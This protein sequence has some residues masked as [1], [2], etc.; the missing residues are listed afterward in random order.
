MRFPIVAV[1]ELILVQRSNYRLH[2][3]LKEKLP[4]YADGMYIPIHIELL[5]TML[6]EQMQ[7][8]YDHPEDRAA[9]EQVIKEY[10]TEQ[11]IYYLT[12]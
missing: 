5:Q 3:W 9:I 1:D 11:E 4:N 12:K 10:S 6:Q 7:G 8:E 2:N